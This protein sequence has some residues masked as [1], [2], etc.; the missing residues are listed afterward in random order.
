M[1]ILMLQGGFGAGGAEKV[2]AR[3][4]AHRRD[5]GDE[6]I[7]G[8][9]YMPDEGSF[10]AYPPDV[11]L[12]VLAADAPAGRRVHFYRLAAI[13]RLIRREQP[14]LILSFLT[15]INCLS[16]MAA[17]GTGVPVVISERN[18]PR[19]QSNCFWRRFQNILAL[20]AAGVVMQTRGQLG[21]LPPRLQRRASVIPNP[22]APVDFRPAPPSKTCRFVAVGRLDPQKGFDLLIRAFAGLSEDI[23]AR[24][25]I[26]GEGPQ[27]P[28]LEALIAGLGLNHRI[29][30][31]GLLPGPKDWLERGDVLVASSRYEGFMNVVA[32]AT[33]S[34]LPTISFDCPYGPGEMIRNGINGL[35]VPPEDVEG[36][37]AAMTRLARDADLRARLSRH[38]DLVAEQLAPDRIMA[39][40]DEVIARAGGGMRAQSPLAVS[41]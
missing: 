19:M 33:A 1:K 28:K 6:V 37:S 16:M 30:L 8:G 29:S 35:L 24:L 20:R 27:R 31:P 2:M 26:F 12:E 4:A 3:L 23:D 17:T 13:R 32:E 25:D 7:V 41:A 15:K 5:E 36:L 34:G 40:W 21:D 14:D 38:A 9:M 10:F 18:N 22:C 39:K 11:R